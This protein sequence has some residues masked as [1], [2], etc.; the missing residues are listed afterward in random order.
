[1]LL[2]YT[3]TQKKL[4]MGT[5]IV[6]AGEVLAGAGSSSSDALLLLLSDVVD[7]ESLDLHALILDVSRPIRTGETRRID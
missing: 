7:S 2:F 6:V 5:K 4:H 1:M 3:H